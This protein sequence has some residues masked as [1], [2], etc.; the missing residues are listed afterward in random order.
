VDEAEAARRASTQTATS[1]EAALAEERKGRVVAVQQAQGA[2]EQRISAA[3]GALDE[4]RQ[5]LRLEAAREVREAREAH[6]STSREALDRLA[7]A[8]HLR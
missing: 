8:A 5:A 1:A 2:A 7:S 6:L 3:Q 4:E